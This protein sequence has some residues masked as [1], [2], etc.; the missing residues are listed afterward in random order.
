MC[1]PAVPFCYCCLSCAEHLGVA[2]CTLHFPLAN[3]PGLWLMV[4]ARCYIQARCLTLWGGGG[5][6]MNVDEWWY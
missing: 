2:Y 3:N 4:P 1:M 5:W 6:I